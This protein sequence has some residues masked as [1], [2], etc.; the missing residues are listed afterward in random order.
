MDPM[1][2]PTMPPMATPAGATPA[3]SEVTGSV[4][5]GTSP[6]PAPPAREE[7]AKVDAEKT[8]AAVRPAVIGSLDEDVIRSVDQLLSR[9][10]QLG[11]QGG[12]LRIAAGA[13]LEL[14]TPCD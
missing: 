3:E 6:A 2:L 14:P 1:N 7:P 9:L 4:A 10:K 5:A 13:D 12:I 8:G 11:R